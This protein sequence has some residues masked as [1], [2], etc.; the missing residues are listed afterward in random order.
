M[1]PFSF[2]LQRNRARYGAKGIPAEDQ[3][4]II[5]LKPGV[6]QLESVRIQHLEET[7]TLKISVMPSP[8]LAPDALKRIRIDLHGESGLVQSWPLEA[9]GTSLNPI[10]KGAYR[11]SLVEVLAS[12]EKHQVRYLGFVEL[13]LN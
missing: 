11:L 7:G 2:L 10:E 5:D 1:C 9:S 12:I 6:E 8:D 13:D 3:Y 4:E